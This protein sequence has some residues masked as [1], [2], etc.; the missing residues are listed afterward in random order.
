MVR[1]R[2]LTTVKD[3]NFDEYE[4]HYFYVILISLLYFYLLYLLS[5][6]TTIYVPEGQRGK[7]S[8]VEGQKAKEVCWPSLFL[9]NFEKKF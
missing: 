4:L 1:L 7:E 5:S 9:L 6:M 2:L 8:K 3:V